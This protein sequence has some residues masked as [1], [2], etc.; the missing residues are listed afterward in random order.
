MEFI[1]ITAVERIYGITGD[2]Q[3]RLVMETKYVN[4]ILKTSCVSYY[5]SCIIHM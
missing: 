2:C 4:C 3:S 1:V 5:N